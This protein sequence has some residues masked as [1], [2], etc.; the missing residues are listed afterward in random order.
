M[1]PNKK[2]EEL[3]I[4]A[5]YKEVNS[6]VLLLIDN[7]PLINTSFLKGIP[8]NQ[9]LIIKFQTGFATTYFEKIV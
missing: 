8:N 5:Y 1:R 6:K 3:N 2:L 7:L 4:S 9:S